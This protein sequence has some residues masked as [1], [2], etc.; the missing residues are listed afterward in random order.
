MEGKKRTENDETNPIASDTPGPTAIIA[1]LIKRHVK[2][3][4]DFAVF[5]SFISGLLI[6]LLGLLNLG[7]LV[8]FI[9]IP[10]VVGFTVA[11]ALTIGSSQVKSLLGLRGS[12]NEFIPAW[13]NVWNHIDETKLWDTVL[14]LSTIFLLLALRVSRLKR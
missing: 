3:N 7:F 12:T 2:D 13:I 5:M 8:Q 10:V 11:G 4:P 6:F 9:S 14:G 1:L